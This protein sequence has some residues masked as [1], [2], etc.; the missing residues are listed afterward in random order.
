MAY[1]S[2]YVPIRF[3]A[4]STGRTRE[5]KDSELNQISNALKNFNKS[6]SVFTENYKTE[7]QDEAQDVFDNLK[8]Q[9][10]T[11]PDEIKKMIEE[12]ITDSFKFGPPNQNFSINEMATRNL[13]ALG[14]DDW[15]IEYDSEKPDGQFRK[16]VSSEKMMHC[17][18]E[19]DF[20]EFKSG[21][22]RVYNAIKEIHGV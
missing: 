15:A 9:G 8:A 16:D 6:F 21:V 3:Q 11:D 22:E 18:G 4:T 17:L 10:I 14:K 2:Q 7:Q 13:E 20:I 12:D 1:K 5:A 19:Y